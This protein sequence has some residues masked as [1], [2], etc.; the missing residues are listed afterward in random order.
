MFFRKHWPWPVRSFN[1]ESDDVSG[2]RAL[3][4]KNCHIFWRDKIQYVAKFGEGRNIQLNTH[5][6]KQMVGNKTSLLAVLEH[7]SELVEN[8]AGWGLGFGSIL[9]LSVEKD[10]FALFWNYIRQ[11]IQ[12][13]T[14][15]FTRLE[16]SYDW[17]INVHH[18]LCH[19]GSYSKTS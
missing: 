1:V 13:R 9:C 10:V 16:D 18:Q 12:D 17:K 4:I 14:R 8:Q 2:V 19:V 3:L 5:Q 7:L 6:R 15:W 11:H